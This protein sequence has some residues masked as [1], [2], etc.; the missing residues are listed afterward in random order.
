MT[1][2]QAIA[3]AAMGRCVAF[4][5]AGFSREAENFQG[6]KLKE[7]TDLADDL[8]EAAGEGSGLNLRTAAQAYV[9]ANKEPPLNQVI[10]TA[11]SVKTAA[12][13]QLD[14][15]RLPWR[16]IYTTN[17]D[18]SIELCLRKIGIDPDPM[19]ASDHP[20]RRERKFGVPSAR[21][22]RSTSERGRRSGFGTD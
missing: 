13:E 9:D 21:I 6:F 19:V 5:G 8:G 10:S 11:F 14:I 20:P 3:K 1:F 16:S 17:Y 15:L 7:A 18:D 22:R 12:P 4:F 2:E